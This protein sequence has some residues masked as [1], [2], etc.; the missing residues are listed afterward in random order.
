MYIIPRSCFAAISDT[1]KSD[2]CLANENKIPE[3]KNQVWVG[4]G[5][6]IVPFLSRLYWLKHKA[7][8]Q[9]ANFEKIHLF[10]CMNSEKEAFFL[11]E[12]T[13]ILAHLDFIELHILDS[14]KEQR[15][16]SEQIVEKVDG[17]PFNVSFCGPDSFG[18][19]LKLN[20]EL[21]GLPKNRFQKEIFRMR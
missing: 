13:K 1:D 6:G 3:L 7:D 17:K 16:D 15:L 20:L 18:N 12:I 5:I 11:T 14:E 8:K 4:A 19:E 10:Y 21:A 9:Q 2:V